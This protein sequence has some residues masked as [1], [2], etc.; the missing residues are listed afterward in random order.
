[1]V[2]YRQKP[3]FQFR[4]EVIIPC[5]GVQTESENHANYQSS[6]A[7]GELVAWPVPAIFHKELLVLEMYAYR[8]WCSFVRKS[9]QPAW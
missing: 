7:L 6:H 9:L 4:R 1:M 5:R 8:V 3:F 2:D